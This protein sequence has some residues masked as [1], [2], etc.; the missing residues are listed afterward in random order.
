MPC[1]GA[2]L[3]AAVLLGLAGAGQ[4]TRIEVPFGSLLSSN[5]PYVQATVQLAVE[6][7]NNASLLGL[8]TRLGLPPQLVLRKLDF[9]SLP[10]AGKTFTYAA[11]APN[12][13]VQFLTQVPKPWMV[14]GPTTSSVAVTSVLG[15]AHITTVAPSSVTGD[16]TT[17][18]FQTS[19]DVALA[20]QGPLLAAV[21]ATLGWSRYAILHNTLYTDV[22]ASFT[23]ATLARGGQILATTAFVSSDGNVTRTEDLSAQMR[24]LKASGARVF[25]VLV[26]QA[27]AL[28]V[29]RQLRDAGLTGA[30]YACMGNN[31]WLRYLYSPNVLKEVYESIQGCV[32]TAIG[33]PATSPQYLSYLAAYNSKC[34]RDPASMGTC[35]S[36]PITS[37]LFANTVMGV[38]YSYRALYALLA[39]CGG[40]PT[41]VYD[42][43]RDVYTFSG[44][45]VTGWRTASDP[46]CAPYAPMDAGYMLNTLLTSP[47]GVAAFD[48]LFGRV[49]VG[50]DG[51]RSP[52]YQL[53]N[54]PS[55]DGVL[56]TI[57]TVAGLTN[58]TYTDRALARWPGGGT[59]VPLDAPVVLYDG[60]A[61]DLRYDLGARLQS[62][63]MTSVIVFVESI[64]LEDPIYRAHTKEQQGFDYVLI[65]AAAFVK[66]VGIWS[67]FC[68]SIKQLSF[69]IGDATPNG[70]TF[71]PTLVMTTWLGVWLLAALA[72][73]LKI[74]GLRRLVRVRRALRRNYKVRPL[75]ADLEA[76]VQE[77]S[78]L[79]SQ[80]AATS[81]TSA[82]DS[83][84]AGGGAP[85]ATQMEMEEEE[86][87]AEEVWW[88]SAWHTTCAMAGTLRFTDLFSVG[89]VLLTFGALAVME[90]TGAVALRLPMVVTVN[91]SP[92]LPL[93]LALVLPG[94]LLGL[95][96]QMHLHA[97]QWVAVPFLAMPII[98]AHEALVHSLSFRYST[99]LAAGYAGS[100][101]WWTIGDLSNVS[102]GVAGA[103]CFVL[104]VI[105]FLRNKS[106]SRGQ[107]QAIGKL[108]ALV[109]KLQSR[110]A[111]TRGQAAELLAGLDGAHVLLHLLSLGRP[112]TLKHMAAHAWALVQQRAASAFTSVT[113]PSVTKGGAS[114]RAG[115]H[116]AV[117]PDTGSLPGSSSTGE[118]DAQD[119]TF[120]LG[121]RR[122]RRNLEGT[123]PGSEGFRACVEALR[124]ATGEHMA[125]KLLIEG[126]DLTTVLQHP[127]GVARFEEFLQT[128]HASENLRFIQHV[129]IYRADT[130]PGNR[131][132]LGAEIVAYFIDPPNKELRDLHLEVNLPGPMR[133]KILA[134]HADGA[135][136]ADLFAAA[137][138]EILALMNVNNF[139][140]FQMTDA[141][142]MLV[143]LMANKATSMLSNVSAIRRSLQKA[144][145]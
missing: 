90:A 14:V 133:T 96:L 124:D 52:V 141:Y 51:T 91:L 101:G 130:S 31:E 30:P 36:P 55:T 107:A 17:Y 33:V 21:G 5:S 7:V 134:A 83:T 108:E 18:P 37:Q 109:E 92:L 58:V 111:R 97:N 47:S 128:T 42:A 4:A 145:S 95:Q 115:H 44:V 69:V 43:V 70:L 10:T 78:L 1:V 140:K 25:V 85:S 61:L 48:S 76:S 81:A 127:Y 112:I 32:G 113:A 121:D 3:L 26:L 143:A 56:V 119:V 62:Y 39:R 38:A 9:A 34:R 16:R 117:Q 88:R 19:T 49:T 126:P 74:V 40:R 125:Q 8:D 93:A 13:A 116:L 54:V 114:K 63:I 105:Q 94:M 131:A 82:G 24:A 103:C 65:V 77:G 84:S 12:V 67:A 139:S 100:N 53:V 73:L 27:D 64:L 87:E 137:E 15:P 122:L 59:A 123:A 99:E 35:P 2:V 144:S 75:G 68:F 66:A 45:N 60:L 28:T 29:F 135:Y 104:I 106:T 20:A 57:G 22:V 80:R 129:Q 72:S 46:T 120:L 136:P 118:C 142:R 23:A 6:Q 132:E 89:A 86:E 79:T 50:S 110:L 102:L 71:D 11:G 138:A 41:Y 98:V